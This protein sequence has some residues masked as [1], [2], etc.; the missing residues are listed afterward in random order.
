MRYHLVWNNVTSWAGLRQSCKVESISLRKMASCREVLQFYRRTTLDVV[1][2]QHEGRKIRQY[3]MIQKRSQSWNL[4]PHLQH[5]YGLWA[6]FWARSQ[7]DVLFSIILRTLSHTFAKEVPELIHEVRLSFLST[8]LARVLL[9]WIKFTSLGRRFSC[10]S[11]TFLVMSDC[12]HS[13]DDLGTEDGRYCPLFLGVDASTAMWMR[14]VKWSTAP[15]THWKS[16][17]DPALL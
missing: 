1:S 15:S 13:S 17:R 11:I 3:K 5:L 14:D 7:T 9:W 10:H 6:L 4:L 16:S 2:V 12:W 8:H